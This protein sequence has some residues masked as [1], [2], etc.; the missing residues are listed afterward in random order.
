MVCF[1]PLVGDFRRFDMTV[2]ASVEKGDSVSFLRML[3]IL[4]EEG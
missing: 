4:R 2:F 3:F 1:L